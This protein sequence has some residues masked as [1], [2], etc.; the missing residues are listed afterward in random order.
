MDAFSFLLGWEIRG[1]TGSIY[2][3]VALLPT[4]PE[5]QPFDRRKFVACYRL[6]RLTLEGITDVDGLE[7]ERQPVWNDEPGEFQD[8][9]ALVAASYSDGVLTFETTEG[10]RRVRCRSAELTL[11]SDDGPE[12][13]ASS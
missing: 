13:F 2:L 1:S 7:G 9:D 10:V 3:E 6:A 4:H 5:H 11:L 8:V 12:A